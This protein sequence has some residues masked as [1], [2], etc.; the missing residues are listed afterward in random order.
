[1]RLLLKMQTTPRGLRDS[2]TL[3]AVKLYMIFS[4]YSY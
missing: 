3:P 1:M 4:L 2:Q